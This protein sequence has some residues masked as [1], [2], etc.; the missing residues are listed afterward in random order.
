VAGALPAPEGGVPPLRPL[1]VREGVRVADAVPEPLR[2]GV[3][4]DEAEGVSAGVSAGLQ[5]ALAVM[6][7]EAP[8]VT[9]AEGGAAGVPLPLAVGEG[10]AEGVPLP[11][12]EGDAVG[13]PVALGEGVA[14]ALC[15]ALPVPE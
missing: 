1:R 9:A 14:E 13:V 5:V 10:E 11:V 15:D 12:G 6:D 4:V 8:G 3:P 2:V 7:G